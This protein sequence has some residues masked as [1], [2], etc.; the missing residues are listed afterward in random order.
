[1]STLC[2]KSWIIDVLMVFCS[3]VMMISMVLSE[4]YWTWFLHK[5]YAFSSWWY[6]KKQGN[7]FRKGKNLIL[8]QFVSVVCLFCSVLTF[9]EHMWRQFLKY[10]MSYV[11]GILYTKHFFLKMNCIVNNWSISQ[12]K[13]LV[14]FS[15]I[16]YIVCITLVSNTWPMLIMITNTAL[17]PN[18]KTTYR[19][20]NEIHDVYYL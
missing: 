18:V 12:I 4:E 10:C 16:K 17:I 9:C 11:Q 13:K 6:I 20:Y 8:K 5:Y 1:M 2:I 14:F 7:E 19:L 15:E 3:I